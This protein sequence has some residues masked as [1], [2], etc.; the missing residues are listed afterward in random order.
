M[1]KGDARQACAA[2]KFQRRKCTP[3]CPLAPYF[4]SDKPEIFHNVH[5]LFG[6]K[7]LIKTLESIGDPSQRDDAMTSMIYQAN[8]RK[9]FPVHGCCKVIDLYYYKIQL[10]EQELDAVYAK[11]EGYRS[12]NG[13]QVQV[14]SRKVIEGPNL[15]VIG[16]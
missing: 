8:M 2:C 4:P 15:H 6:V 10:L 16:C 12:C 9:M 3:E 7:K 11:L 14:Q 13:N 1:M 5:R